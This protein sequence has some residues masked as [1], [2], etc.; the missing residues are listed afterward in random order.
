VAVAAI[1]PATL[2]PPRV[3]GPLT[4]TPGLALFQCGRVL[5]GLASSNLTYVRRLCW[6]APFPMV[7]H[8]RSSHPSRH[9]SRLCPS[10]MVSSRLQCLRLQRHGPY[11]RARGINNRW[12]TPST[13]WPWFLLRSLIGLPTLTP[14]TTP[15]WMSVTQPLSALLIVMI[16]HLSLWGTDPL[17]RLPQ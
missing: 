7:L 14:P 2:M 13:P 4:S 15:S 5:R 6:Q 17:S 3:C 9:P 12:P 1:A 16:L 8:S 10:T 11:G